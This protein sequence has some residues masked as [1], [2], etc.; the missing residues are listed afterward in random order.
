MHGSGG[1]AAFAKGS[2]LSLASLSVGQVCL[3]QQPF[4]TFWIIAGL[5]FG[6]QS[7]AALSPRAGGAQKCNTPYVLVRLRWLDCCT[8]V[9]NFSDYAHQ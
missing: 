9:S 5:T 3:P 1:G 7:G 4:H 8:H 6:R 2:K